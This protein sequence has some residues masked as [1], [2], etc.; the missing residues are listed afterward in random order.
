MTKE[1]SAFLNEQS[2]EIDD[3]VREAIELCGG[4]PLLALYTTIVANKF[5]SEDNARLREENVTLQKQSSVGFGR[6]RIARS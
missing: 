4:S 6:K 3:M 2:Q 1:L 5:L